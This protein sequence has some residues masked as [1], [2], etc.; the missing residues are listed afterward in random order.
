MLLK[1][2]FSTPEVDC[3]SEEQAIRIALRE[4]TDIRKISIDFTRKEVSI[5]HDD[6]ADGQEQIRGAIPFRAVL[7]ESKP[8]DPQDAL[9]LEK[10]DDA[11]GERK[12]LLWLLGLNFGMFLVEV[13]IGVKAQSS[14]LVADGL[15]M[16]ADSL[17]YFLS[18]LSVSLGLSG[19]VRATRLSAALQG[20]LGVLALGQAVWRFIFGSDPEPAWMTSI[21]ALA[22]VVNVTCLLLISRFRTG[23]MHMQ[24][25][26]IFS[27]ND[28]IANLA[29]IIAGLLVAWSGSHYPDL[30]VGVGICVLVLTG[31]IKINRLARSTI[32]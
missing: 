32:E 19:R 21:S 15:D 22:L 14:G 30:F 4:R 16:L 5:I 20:S 1:S 25:S 18:L 26:W 11:S 23:R 31:A 28:V 3:P 29:V 9:E 2:R 6:R 17:V 8:V 24:A 13:S 27:T 7:L 12:V 10:S